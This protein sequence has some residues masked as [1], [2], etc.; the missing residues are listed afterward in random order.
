LILNMKMSFSANM[1]RFLWFMQLDYV[2]SDLHNGASD[3][4]LCSLLWRSNSAHNA[5]DALSLLWKS[6]LTLNAQ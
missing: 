1:Q 5:R 4:A 3:M 2:C 6:T